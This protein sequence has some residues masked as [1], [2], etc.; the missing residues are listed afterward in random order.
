MLNYIANICHHNQVATSDGFTIK[1]TAVKAMFAFVLHGCLLSFGQVLLLNVAFKPASLQNS[2]T[3][4][5]LFKL[6]TI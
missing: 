1:K 5:D 3:A 4:I 2:E 6:T